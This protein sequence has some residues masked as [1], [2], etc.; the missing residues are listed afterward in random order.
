MFTGIIQSIGKISSLERGASDLRIG[1]AIGKLA[2][3]AIS[4]GDSIA[5]NGVCLTVVGIGSHSFVADVSNETLAC[6][7]LKELQV[8]S[9]V[10]L[11]LA[12][13]PATRMGGHIVSG[14]V[15]GVGVILDQVADGR[16][17]RFQIGMPENLARYV[18]AKGSICVDGISLTVNK[19]DPHCFRVNIVR[20]TLAET[21]LG[22]AT[23]GQRVNLEVDLLARYLERLLSERGPESGQI[24][25]GACPRI[26]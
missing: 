17:V 20:H 8:A 10:N 11:E 14:H 7:T 13:T 1:V 6:T 2:S 25:L 19:V 23:V 3:E 9:P 16:S 22:R 15:D 24:D 5:V 4:V 12:L 26:D 18:A 21:T